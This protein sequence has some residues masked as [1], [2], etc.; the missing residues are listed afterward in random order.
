[1]APPDE[2]APAPAES[3][4]PAGLQRRRGATAAILFTLALALSPGQLFG[5]MLGVERPLVVEVDRGVTTRDGTRLSVDIYRPEGD[6]RHPTVF[7]STPYNNNGD[8]TVE[9]A[10]SFVRRGYAYVAADTRGRY[11]SQGD[12]DPYRSDGP[13][14]AEV[15][16]WIT[17]QPWSDGTVVTTGGSYG[18][19]NQWLMAREASPHHR[20][21]VSY[22]APS[23][24]F[25]HGFRH[26]GIPK[27][28]LS[29]TW[30]AGMYGRV[31]QSRSGFDWNRLQATLPLDELD[32]AAGR[33]IPWWKNWVRNGV[34][35]AYWDS[36]GFRGRYEAFDIP[37]FNVSGWWD[38]QLRGAVQHYEESVRTGRV[39]DHMLVIGPWL[40][41]VNR[42]RTIGVRDYGPE[43]IIDL[44]GIRDAWMDHR[45]LGGPRPDLPNV[46]YFLPV[47]NEWRA[48]DAWPIP[49]TEFRRY[50]L[51]S[52]GSAN[53]LLGTGRLAAAAP[54]RDRPDEF[55]YD[56]ANPVPT[57]SS[58]TSGARGGLP[59]GSVDN[60]AVE[61]REDVLVYTTEPLPAGMEIT[62]PVRA[63]IHFSTDVP[64]TDITVKLLDVQADGRAL[65]ISHG[66][67]RARFRNSYSEPELL[68]AGEVYMVEVE[69][70]PTSNYFEA[71]NRIRIEVSSSDF[72]N[73]ARN[74]NTAESSDTGRQIQLARTRIHHSTRYP[75]HIELPVVPAGSARRWTP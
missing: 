70:F 57:V 15:M 75:S 24:R 10:W 32:E 73:F 5:Q 56:P 35:N 51:D 44:N 33:T 58:R 1:M 28:D 13:D 69:L 23:D 25:L 61:T 8:N 12:F 3:A 71:G 4:S 20:A 38:G 50:H 68:E 2:A 22:V 29:F 49:R 67:A 60:R 39:E 14:G 7:T 54:A 30:S 41:G 43:A 26:D 55:V 62:G 19:I 31:N 37:S 18:G 46:L 59:Q 72:P 64:D 17:A 65:N 74:L 53:T 42:N 16:A 34:L 48:A 45:M 63:R 27:L 9:E 11:D 52:D 66:I 36:V 40:H 47:L 21:I 6:G